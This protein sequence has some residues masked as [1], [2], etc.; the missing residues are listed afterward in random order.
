MGSNSKAAG[1]SGQ[2]RAQREACG[3]EDGGLPL[4]MGLLPHS[5]PLRLLEK[6]PDSTMTSPTM[7]K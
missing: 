5:C 1:N 2:N 7:R 4:E 3:K 6:H